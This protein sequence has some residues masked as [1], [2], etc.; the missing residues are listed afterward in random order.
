MKAKK[1]PGIKSKYYISTNLDDNFEDNNIN[2][3]G[4]LK[5]DFLGLNFNLFD[6]LKSSNIQVEKNNSNILLS[7]KYVTSIINYLF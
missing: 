2:I 3:I 6:K 1:M 4:V 7:I 5:S